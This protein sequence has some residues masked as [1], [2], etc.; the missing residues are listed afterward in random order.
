MVSMGTMRSD[1]KNL[2]LACLG[3]LAGLLAVQMATAQTPTL[4]PPP[5]LPRYDVEIQLDV[6]GHSAHARETVTWINHYQRP[7]LELVFNAHSHFQLE[8]KDVPLLAKTLEILRMNPSEAMES[9]T[10]PPPL[11]ITRVRLGGATLPLRYQEANGKPLNVAPQSAV[12]AGFA[13]PGERGTALV[14]PLPRAVS[15]GESVT[16]EIEFDFRLPQKQGRWGQWKGVTFLVNWLPVVAVYDESGWQ[17]TPF[18]PWHLPFFNEAGLYS[19]QLT[20]PCEQ[21]IACSSSIERQRD[22]GNGSKEVC[23]APRIVRDFAL[24]CSDLFQDHVAQIGG[25]EVHCFSLPEHDHYGQELVRWVCEAIPV[26]SQ[27]I[28][29]FPYSSFTVVESYFGW[30]GNQCGG[31]VMID[32]RVFNF[33]HAAGPFL[34]Q[35]VSH[36]LC[37]QWWY[38]VIGINGY[39]ETWMSEAMATYFSNKLMDRKHGKNDKLLNYPEGLRWLPNIDR[40]TYRNYGLQGSIARGDATVTVQ[41]LPGY[42]HLV[43]LLSMAYDRGSKI[44]AM[45]EERLGEDAFC[46]LSHRIYQRYYFR[47]LRVADYQHEIVDYTRQPDCW[48]AFFRNWIYGKAMCDW[49]VAN[50]KV[51][52]AHGAGTEPVQE[53]LFGLP[54]ISRAS[55]LLNSKTADAEP[56]HVSVKLV[57]KA[58]C[59][60]RTTLGISFDGT[61]DY[62]IRLPID[63]YTPVVEI[64]DPPARVEA[65]ADGTVQVEMDL[66]CR[67]TQIAVDPDQILV[68]PNPD[69]NFWKTPVRWRFA[70]INTPLEETAV[71][72]AYDRPNFIFGP[73]LQGS[74]YSDPWYARSAVVGL[75]AALYEGNHFDIGTY[76]GYRTDYQD[77]VIGADGLIDHWPWSHT[78]VGFN[79][80]YGLTPVGGQDDRESNRGVVFGRYVFLYNSSLYLPPAHYLEA[81][82]MVQTNA[83]PLPDTP[84]PGADHFDQQTALGLHWHLDYETPYW[85]PEGG[86]RVDASFA[87]GIP[88]FGEHQS[89][90]QLAAQFAGVRYLPD[91][92]GPLSQTKVA[93]RIQGGAAWPDNAQLFSLGGSNSFRGFDLKERQGNMFW[94][95]SLEWRVPVIRQVEWDCFD[96]FVGVRN[97]Y[98]AAFYDVGNAYL[99]HEQLGPIAHAL[100]LG[101]RIDVAWL[102]M[103]ERTTLRFDVA[104]TVNDDTPWQFWFGIQTPF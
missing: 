93:Y 69:N 100:G 41:E 56:C 72:T 19:V 33:P 45:I 10:A 94:V 55:S 36:E 87:E 71:T 73:G 18:V 96:H 61:E 95:A 44:L 2:W 82:G 97:V 46:D 11:E 22:L 28:G 21:K 62:T 101:L 104:K 65:L 68:D 48:D 88:I 30:N 70:P 80:E 74:A 92:L 60:E 35:L 47:I 77:L 76:L 63:P 84:T 57:Q 14:I 39:C 75:R 4:A 50:V 102:S 66:P 37:H 29:P 42:Q 79:V 67:P 1:C 99:N 49:S 25:V 31:L 85:D 38:N 16:V 54:V 8:S 90:Q 9:S 17:P 7:A 51:T 6:E 32:E 59:S 5:W 81:F 53:G 78:Q 27:W 40:R 43:T 86:Y 3:V 91:W 12:E 64:R 26:Y 52:P 58:D 15:C 83:L 23:F 13:G 89:Y 98:A 103:I 24:I 20:L 34:E